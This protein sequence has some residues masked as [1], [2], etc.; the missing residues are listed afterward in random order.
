MSTC[1]FPQPPFNTSPSKRKKKKYRQYN[2]TTMQTAFF[3]YYIIAF[4]PCM[5][6]VYKA[7]GILF[8]QPC[9]LLIN[10][11]RAYSYSTAI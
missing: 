8:W 5:S 2:N 10:T 11:C 7:G 4:F 3:P 6:A 1:T 9:E